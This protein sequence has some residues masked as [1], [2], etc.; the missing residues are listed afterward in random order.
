MRSRTRPVDLVGERHQDP[1]L[2][3]LFVT[4]Y[5]QK[6]S[7][8]ELLLIHLQTNQKDQSREYNMSCTAPAKILWMCY[9][10]MTGLTNQR[11][12]LLCAFDII[13]SEKLN[14]IIP[15]SSF[16]YYYY[17]TYSK[18]FSFSLRWLQ[19]VK[20]Q[21]RHLAYG[22]GMMPSSLLS[23]KNETDLWNASVFKFVLQQPQKN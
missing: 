11:C 23:K 16:Y 4:R 6:S 15:F 1:E 7:A 5:R 18:I 12:R 19:A 17:H 20:G 3:F 13:W 9:S 10:L 22:V 2:H 8:S 21:I 14:F